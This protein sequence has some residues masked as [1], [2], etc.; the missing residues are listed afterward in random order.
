MHFKTLLT[1]SI[2]WRGFYFVSIFLVNIFLSR[3]L[4]ATAA[5][6]LYYL[7]SIFG[8]IQLL[9]GLSLESGVTYF[10]S[11]GKVEFSKLFWLSFTWVIVA[12]VIIA[13]VLVLY[14]DHFF[15]NYFVSN[16]Q[17]VLYA[18]C[19]ISGQ[20]MITYGS[21]LFYAKGNFFVPNL[22]MLVLNL[23]YVAIIP[24]AFLSFISLSVES[25]IA[26]Y[27][28][29]LI[30]QGLIMLFVFAWTNGSFRKIAFPS[31]DQSKKIF[32][33][34]ALALAANVIFFL[35][36]RI[37]YW[38]VNNSPV[39]TAKDLGNYIQVSKLGQI[40]WI[41]PQIIASAVFPQ[42]AS[43]YDFA[44]VNKSIFILA[45]LFA[46]LFLFVFV[47]V[48]LFGNSLFIGVFGNSF[49]EMK[50][51]FL[52]LAPGIYFLSVLAIL[53][54]Y[55]AGKGKVMINVKGAFVALLFVAVADY[56]FV[57]VYGIY[58][59]AF[60]STVGYGFN[61]TYSLACFYKDHRIS[62]SS[63]FKWRLSDYYWLKDMLQ[64]TK[65]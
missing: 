33:Y 27:F 59:A 49:D 36:Y 1:Q 46:Q 48:L 39:C 60:I 22:I 30:A 10:G 41:I 43:G 8:F 25:I 54:A 64:K 62:L 23:L 15:S 5:G 3:Y 38:F 16:K 24:K 58:A 6:W 32:H 12:G 17:L 26:I 63:F 65:E 52:F 2:L 4:Q 13:G 50:T 7:S 11:S 53:S 55:F 45:R 44:E 51:P 57:P 61:L 42:V 20:M 14:S 35:V 47:V 28:F 21:N 37:D 40:L 31:P 29:L 9:T 18:V 19:Y 56:F 34:S